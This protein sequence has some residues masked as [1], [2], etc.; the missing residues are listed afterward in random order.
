MAIGNNEQAPPPADSKPWDHSSHEEF[1]GYYAQESQSPETLERFR[2]QRDL[3][4]SVPELRQGTRLDVADIGC[5]AGTLAMTWAE[6]GHRVKGLDING[7]LIELARKRAAEA[8]LE[9]EFFLGTATDIPWENESVDVCFAPELLEHVAD[10]QAC[11][12]DFTRILR[13]GGALFLSTTNK[14][15]PV[16]QEFNL[17]LYSWY[18]R[19]LKR[20]Y[21]RLSLTTRPRIANYA[22]YPA[23]NWFTF[24]SLREALASRGFSSFYDRFDMAALRDNGALKDTILGLVQALPPLRLLGQTMTEGSTIVAIKAKAD[25]R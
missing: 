9:V 13:P 24:Y 5:G 22:K 8:S 6:L 1:Y 18:P 17:P 12:N 19:F 11:L 20:H 21:E 10:W 4:L 16:Q 7:P 3:I 15:C 2:R 23:V 25:A 14:L